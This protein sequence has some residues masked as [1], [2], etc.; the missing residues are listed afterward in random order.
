MVDASALCHPTSS[1]QRSPPALRPSGFLAFWLTGPPAFRLSGSPPF[2]PLA[3]W[4]SG[5]PAFRLSGLPAF[6][7]TGLRPSTAAKAMVDTSDI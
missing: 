3:F 5:F 6:W 2:R 4:L 1:P 7:L